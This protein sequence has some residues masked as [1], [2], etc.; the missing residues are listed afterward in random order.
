[1]I[2]FAAGLVIGP[3]AAWAARVLLGRVLDRLD[4]KWHG[5]EG[6]Q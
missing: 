2:W 5:A 1:M 4:R 3:V 6:Q